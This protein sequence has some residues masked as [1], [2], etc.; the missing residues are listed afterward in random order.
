MEVI[1]KARF[2]RIAPRKVRL[3]VGLV[4]GLDVGVALAQLKFLRK[5]AARPVVKAIE[6]AVA[7]ARHNHQLEVGTLYIKA[8][9]V[10]GG[11]TLKRFRPRAMGRAGAILKR[12]SHLTVVL[13][14]RS[15]AAPEAARAAVVSAPAKDAAPVKGKE[16]KP[17]KGGSASSGKKAVK[18]AKGGSASGGKTAA[19]AKPAK[20]KKA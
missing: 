6:S 16:A 4:R 19:K 11:P 10:D 5:A 17:A 18:P 2:L 12:T 20:V 15:V 14:P 7:N 13:A 8:I 1:A 9:T 3:V